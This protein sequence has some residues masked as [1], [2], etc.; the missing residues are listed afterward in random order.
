[1]KL[2]LKDSWSDFE[3]RPA[4]RALFLQLGN[5]ARHLLG[6][7]VVAAPSSLESSSIFPWL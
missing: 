7:V 1:M 3:R 4:S 6:R 5:L 2:I